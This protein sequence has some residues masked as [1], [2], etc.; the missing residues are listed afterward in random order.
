[1]EVQSTDFPE[2]CRGTVIYVFYI[3]GIVFASSVILQLPGILTMYGLWRQIG[4]MSI[5]WYCIRTVAGCIFFLWTGPILC[6]LVA[7]VI[8]CLQSLGYCLHL[9]K[10][11]PE[12]LDV[13]SKI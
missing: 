2:G 10:Q 4:D 8:C 5:I 1:M 9:S 11:E 7:L 12:E 13:V 3:L 6:G